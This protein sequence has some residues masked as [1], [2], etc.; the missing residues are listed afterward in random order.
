MGQHDTR[1]R[2]QHYRQDGGPDA[3]APSAL[4]HDVR[5]LEL[6]PGRT[7]HHQHGQRHQ[8]AQQA[9][10]V[11]QAEE[12]AFIEDLHVFP[13]VEGHA[14]QHVA[15]GH[16]EDDR[17]QKP[18]HEQDGI[19]AAAPGGVFALAAE[20]EGHRPQDEREQD[21]EHG[22]VEARERHRVQLR[23][24]GEDGAAPQDQPDLVAFP[25]GADGVDDGAAFDIGA[26]DEGQQRADAQVKAVG[27]RIADQQH[28]HQCPPDQAQHLIGDEFVEN[29]VPFPCSITVRKP[30]RWLHRA[31]F[32]VGPDGRPDP[33]GWP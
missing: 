22:Q 7:V 11:E 28:A 12:G 13:D 2:V 10:G 1:H 25:D 33:C 31:D 9:E 6:Q 32:H 21:G 19:P 26:C 27:H 16:P 15:H 5:G 4:G 18:G 3:E 17:G 14:L 24:G 30:G 29:H 8:A 23:P 20:L